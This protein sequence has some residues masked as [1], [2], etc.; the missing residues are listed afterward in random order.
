MRLPNGY[1]SVVKLSGK[2]RRPFMVRKTVGYDDKAHPVYDVLGYYATRADALQAL[3]KYNE[4][5]YDINLSKSTMKQVYESWKSE[6]F[7]K[8]KPSMQSSMAAA[9]RHCGNVYDVPYK[10]LRKGH[11]QAC[12]D[13]CGKGYSTRSN[14]KIL[15]G[16]L[17]RYAFDHDII[18]KCYSA[19]LRVGEEEVSTKHTIVSDEEVQA[20][21]EHEGE[22]FVDETLFMLYTGTRISEMLSMKCELIDFDENTMVGG[23]KTKAGKNRTI[24]IHPEILNLVKRHYSADNEFLFMKQITPQRWKKEMQ[25]IGFNHLSHDCRHTVRSKLDSA[26]ANRVAID[27]IMG[28]ASSNIGEQVYTHKTANELHDAIKL[29]TYGAVRSSALVTR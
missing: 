5:P 11:M 15:F 19:N 6:E 9:F 12:V 8:L 21:W 2:R 25:K 16:K 14:I 20:L 4:D 29:L 24:P 17:D 23:V 22:P 28:H 13:G 27:R 18:S 3:A 10:N 26:G 1:G 7:E